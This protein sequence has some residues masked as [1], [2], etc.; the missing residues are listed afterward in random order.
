MNGLKSFTSHAHMHMHMHVCM[1]MSSRTQV[2]LQTAAGPP[3]WNGTRTPLTRTPP[4]T[5]RNAV[6]LAV[7]CGT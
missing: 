6:V 5:E 3:Q 1:C 2:A 7:V 4:R